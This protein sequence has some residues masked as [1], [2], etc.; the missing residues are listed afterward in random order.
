MRPGLAVLKWMI[1]IGLMVVVSMM[2]SWL[3]SS[4]SEQFEQLGESFENAIEHAEDDDEE[5]GEEEAEAQTIPL[6]VI[7]DDEVVEMAGVET[8]PLTI[9]TYRSVLRSQARVVS[10]TALLR[11]HAELSALRNEVEIAHVA[12]QS[13]KSEYDRLQKITGSVAKKN[14]AYAKAD[15]LNKQ[16]EYRAKQNN[17]KNQVSAIEQAWGPALAEAIVEP[18]S[19]LTALLTSKKALIEVAQPI[20]VANQ[21]AVSQ[22]KLALQQNKQTTFTADYLSRTGTQTAFP[23]RTSHYYVAETNG[24]K[25]DMWLYAWL[26]VSE[27]ETEGFMLPESAIVWYAGSP[28]VY[29]EEDEGVYV[30][31]PVLKAHTDA[32]GIFVTTGFDVGEALVTAG[33]QMLLSE[34]FR[35]QIHGEDDDD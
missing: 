9:T 30:R 3:N 13:A 1:I 24:L 5:E 17:Y 2:P 4:W 14:I 26:S 25:G 18:E 34:E 12:L 23:Q 7:L 33:A 27:D 8:T 15:W 11:Q 21:P 20:E 32:Q 29:I 35:W 31:H 28:W 22:V 19:P 10:A 16:V 6:T